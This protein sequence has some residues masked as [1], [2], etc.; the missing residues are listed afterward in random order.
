MTL[1]RVSQWVR[2]QWGKYASLVETE[3]RRECE[4]SDR[5]SESEV[6][7]HMQLREQIIF[8]TST[9]ELKPG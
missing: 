7:L 1:A 2:S 9:C 5:T 3:V 6:P 8:K 4:I